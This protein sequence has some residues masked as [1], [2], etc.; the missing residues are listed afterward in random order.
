MDDNIHIY[1]P[2]S[3]I[4]NIK[5]LY[6]EVDTKLSY[7]NNSHVTYIYEYEINDQKYKFTGFFQNGYFMIFIDIY[8]KILQTTISNKKVLLLSF[9]WIKKNIDDKINLYFL[10]IPNKEY[11][12]IELNNRKMIE[13]E[14]N[15]TINDILLINDYNKKICFVKNINNYYKNNNYNDK[16][17]IQNILQGSNVLLNKISNKLSKWFL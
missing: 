13:N 3:I 11:I 15:L 8:D 4:K 14:I 10:N 12:Y 17:E 9:Q 7:V 16:K 5:D 2:N 1:F 6:F